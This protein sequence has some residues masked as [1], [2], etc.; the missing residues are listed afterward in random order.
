[1][2]N[3]TE[4]PNIE[5]DQTQ[6]ALAAVERQWPEAVALMQMQARVQRARYEAFLVEGFTEA[7]AI[8]LCKVPA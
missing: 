7:Q 2:T 8:E 6:A 1:M 3:I 5:R 4:I